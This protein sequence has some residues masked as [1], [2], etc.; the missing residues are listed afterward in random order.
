MPKPSQSLLQNLQASAYQPQ[1]PLTLSVKG[2]LLVCQQV[3]RVVPGK[4]LVFTGE[5]QQQK[6][7]VKLFVHKKRSEVHWQREYEGARRLHLHGILTPE[8]V[9]KTVS[10]EGIKV[11]IFEFI[12][13]Q[14]LA[15][16]WRNKSTKLRYQKL[17]DCM[18]VLCRHHNAGLAHQDLHYANFLLAENNSVYTLDGEEVK[19]HGKSLDKNS[20]MQNL[21]LFLAQTFDLN[22]SLCL[23]LLKHYGQLANLTFDPEQE[24]HFVQTIRQIRQQRIDQYLRKIQRECTDVAYQKYL[25]GYSLCR[26]EYNIPEIKNFLQQPEVVFQN[27]DARFLKRGNTC[28]VKTVQLDNTTYVV[29]RYNP[30]GAWYELTHLGQFTRARLSWINAHLLTFMGIATARPVAIAEFNPQLGQRLSYFICEYLPGQDSWDYFCSTDIKV[31]QKQQAGQAMVDLL[32][33]LGEYQISHGDLKGSNFILD[34][35][36]VFLIDLDGMKQHKSRRTWLRQWQKDKSRFLKNWD[37][38]D[39]YKPWRTFFKKRVEAI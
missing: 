19:D 18:T 13:G 26:R 6:V 7:I 35:E 4:R 15:L 38:K 24:K 14:N 27:R 36:K 31:E 12:P 22:N 23:S 34:K 5:Y 1:L 39:C 37:K 2:Q 21:A 9:Q 32:D 20:R 16:F 17:H 29:K 10:D 3:L 11:L 8:I 33:R 30:K 25:Q 28:T